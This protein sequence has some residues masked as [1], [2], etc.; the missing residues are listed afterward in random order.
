MSKKQIQRSLLSVFSILLF[1]GAVPVLQAVTTCPTGYNLVS[2]V[3]IPSNT[4]L[5]DTPVIDIIGEFMF[6][7]LSI[8]GMLAVI[9]FVISGIQYITSAGDE[10]QAETAKNNMKYA[11]IGVIVA[12]SGLVI[13]Q[14]VEGVLTATPG[15]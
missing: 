2:G 9:A 13:I 14:A 11:I 12:L 6:W 5:P 8:F 10:G 15:F 7:L 4:G 1:A 3:C